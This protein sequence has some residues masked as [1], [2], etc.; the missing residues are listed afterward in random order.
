MFTHPNK[1]GSN[2]DHI[3]YFAETD[4]RGKRVKFGIKDSDRTKHIYMIGK[5]GMGKSTLLENLAVQD[6]QNGNGLCFID[7]HGSAVDTFLDYI[8]A[9]RVDDVVY[10][11]PFDFE[12]P[13]AF[14]VMEDVDPDK[15]SLVAQ[16]LLSSFKKIWGE[17]T[18][19][20]RMEHIV[21]NT[22][23]ALLEYPNSTMLSISRMFVDIPF[24]KKVI[25]NIS[26]PVVKQFWTQEYASWSDTYR[27]DAYSAI[28][29][30]IGQFTSNPVIRNI[31]G[32][33]KSSFDL[34]QC[35]DEQK[36]VLVNLSIG[37]V[38][39]ANANLLGSMLTTKIFLAGMSRASLSKGE[40]SQVPNFYLYIDEFQNLANDSFADI[41]SQSRKYKLNL[42]LAHQYI[43]QMPE[44]VRA[45]VFGNVGTMITFRVGATDAEIFEREFGMRFLASDF[46]SLDRYQIY[47]TLMIDGAGSAPFSARTLPPLPVPAVSL[48]QEVIAHSRAHFARSREEVEKEIANWMSASLSAPAIKPNNGM[49]DRKRKQTIK[50][51]RATKPKVEDVDLPG[52][53][54]FKEALAHINL[55]DSQDEK[56]AQ[57]KNT[58]STAPKT[59]KEEN[60]N[61]KAKKDDD[62]S[63]F[64]KQI[65]ES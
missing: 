60:K 9:H 33:S 59:N 54:D 24:Q 58:P 12:H 21:S 23:L 16:G 15:R 39:E 50:S 1:L 4:A 64:I 51:P 52:T 55:P 38:G 43:E 8:P 57:Q 3:T 37:Q 62:L 44:T 49:P 53:H 11:A 7:P 36:I 14:N 40:L 20:D 63:D 65:G 25:A 29:N 31:V 27:R 22:L 42:T 32:Q 35:M 34:R 30:K 26:D 56:I 17:E 19:S 45:A 47:L 46:V 10:I 13:V 2:D 6:I 28:L 61:I 48:R 5:S 41:L 18:F